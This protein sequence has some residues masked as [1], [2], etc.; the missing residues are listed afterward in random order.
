M[1]TIIESLSNSS[2]THENKDVL[3]EITAEKVAAWDDAVSDSH[4]HTNKNVLDTIDSTKVAAWDAAEAN[5]SAYTDSA[6]AG[7]N[8][9]ET[10]EAKGAAESALTE[11]KLYVDGKVVSYDGGVAV[12]VDTDNK[13]NVLV[14]EST[15]DITNWLKVKEGNTLAVNEIGLDDAV[16]T[17]DITIEGGEWATAVKKVFTDGKVPSGTSWQSFLESMLCVEKFAGTITTTDTFNVTCSAPGA[18]ITGATNGKTAEVGTKVTLA[19]VSHKSTIANQSIT[20]KTFSYGYK[21]GE[22]GAYNR[23]TAYTETLTPTL[24]ATSTN[25]KETFTKFTDAQG[26]VLSAI[27]GTDSLDAVIMYV[28]DGENKVVVA[29]TGDTYVSSSAVTAGTI[30]VATNLKNYYKNDKETPNTY[31]PAAAVQTK[32]STNSSTY[33]V[34]GYRNTFYGTTSDLS[35]CDASFVRSLTKSGKAI[36]NGNTL[37]ITTKASDNHMRMVIASPRTIKSVKN[38]TATQDITQLLLNTHT[39]LE[40]PGDNSYSP[41]SYNVYDNTWKEAFGSDEWIITFN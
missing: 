18:G 11:A 21:L 29:Q 37:S 35:T 20:S 40:V 34:T 3:D 9:A 26:N 8:L 24:S 6:I 30:Y 23:A 17:K 41:I 13:I 5:A 14:E 10:Y 28:N 33:T 19:A 32:T 39:T 22:N 4:T 16:T 7:L 1:N 2:H 38:K 31:K 27:T 36:A 25:L 12:N 15:K